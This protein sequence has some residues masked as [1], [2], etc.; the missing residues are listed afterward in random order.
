MKSL[1]VI[2]TFNEADNINDIVHEIRS[3]APHTDVLIVDDSSPDGTAQIVENLIQNGRPWLHIIKRKG[4]LGLGSA[5]VTGF[6]WG[7]KYHFDIIIEMDADFSHDPKI[8]PS[9]LEA[10]KQN[11]VVIGS[12]YVPG[13]GSLNWSWIRQLISRSGSLY[14]RMVLSLPLNDVTGGFNGWR[15]EVLRS[16]HLD[17]IES[18]GY[19]FQ[20]ELKYRAWRHNFRMIEIPIVFV[21][22]RAGA[23]KMS[24]AIVREAIHRVWSIRSYS[25]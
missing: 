25:A 23:S 8:L 4:K 14:A 16:I 11:D 5:Y 1:V 12:R 10:L 9:M 15:A 20:I 21:E 24:G 7:L 22:R 2:P 19:A 3:N 6:T 18:E 13:G 17:T